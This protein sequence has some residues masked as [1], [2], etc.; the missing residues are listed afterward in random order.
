[1]KQLYLPT[2]YETSILASLNTYQYLLLRQITRLLGRES[3]S[4]YTRERLNILIAEKLVTAQYP[5][6]ASRTG[7]APLVYSLTG[8]GKRFF[9][10]NDEEKTLS[11]GYIE[12]TISV[13]DILISGALLEKSEPRIRLFEMRPEHLFKQHPIRLGKSEFL[14]PDGWQHFKVSPPYGKPGEAI[15]IVYEADRASEDNY[16]IR[17]KIQRYCTLAGGLHR[18][19]FGIDSLT[20]TFVV[21]EGSV[22][23]L[24]Q[25]LT[26]VRQ[27]LKHMTE[28]RDLFLFC[29]VDDTS[30]INP[31]TFFCQ[32]IWIHP[33]QKNRIAL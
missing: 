7:K 27:E 19:V 13:G 5:P 11:G 32:P 18:E 29:T 24:Q 4:N 21:T 25:L 1:M 12:H 9:S 20:I 15:G 16:K 8:K 23:R 26:W 10:E 22:R 31:L 3:I 6:R 30:A 17:E 14:A 33:F 2:K 28:E